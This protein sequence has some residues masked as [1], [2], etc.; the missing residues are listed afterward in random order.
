[1]PTQ[2]SALHLPLV[3]TRLIVDRTA[4]GRILGV[5]IL[6]TGPAKGHGFEVD[7]GLVER[8]AQLGNGIRGRWTHGALGASALGRHLGEWTNLRT[9]HFRVCRSCQLEAETPHCGQCG[10]ATEPALRALGDFEF[11]PSAWKL[12]PDGLDV[13]APDY[14][15]TRAEEDPRS[16]GVSIV[17]P[18]HLETSGE[19]A[20]ART[21]ARI[22]G[23]EL[24]RADWVAD[25]AANPTGLSQGSGTDPLLPFLDQLVAERGEEAARLHLFGV[26]A[27]YF[28]DEVEESSASGEEPKSPQPELQPPSGHE[29]AADTSPGVQQEVAALR[30]QVERV[31]LALE[32]LAPRQAD[33]ALR[34]YKRRAADQGAPLS[35]SQLESLQTLLGEGQHDAAETLATSYLADS[36]SKGQVAHEETA[37]V[38]LRVQPRSGDSLALQARVLSESRRTLPPLPSLTPPTPTAQGGRH[39]SS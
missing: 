16:L 7:E 39:E 29:S 37:V 23:D 25:P 38:P 33:A 1:M 5:S 11:S 27:R 34:S 15:M 10:T 26:L 28:G 12:K 13:P 32:H 31:T 18:L 30:A 21:L 36:A 20:E 14:L 6:T 2:L 8:V 9:Q 19:G 24:L 35:A 3:S 4:P 17:A 22:V